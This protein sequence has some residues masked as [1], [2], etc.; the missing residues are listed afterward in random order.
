MTQGLSRD[1]DNFIS[2]AIIE[3][4]NRNLFFCFNSLVDQDIETPRSAD[5]Y[6]MVTSV[7]IVD[8]LLRTYQV[9][10][11]TVKSR[12]QRDIEDNF[13]LQIRQYVSY[14]QSFGLPYSAMIIAIWSPR[15]GTGRLISSLTLIPFRS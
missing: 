12:P 3:M 5:I 10:E 13:N 2:G 9:L 4:W 8:C 11:V 14:F 1:F 15:V 7:F 6:L